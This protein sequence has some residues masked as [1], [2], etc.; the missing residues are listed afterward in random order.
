MATRK[1]TGGNGKAPARTTTSDK[2]APNTAAQTPSGTV[3][4]LKPAKAASRTAAAARARLAAV[5]S[6]EHTPDDHSPTPPKSPRAKYGRNAL[7]A[8]VAADTGLKRTEVRQVLDAA[9]GRM[10]AA[11]GA[12]R[13]LDL[14]PF[15]KL[16]A[17]K[18]KQGRNGET[19]VCRL[20]LSDAAEKPGAEPLAD[21]EEGR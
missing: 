16:R 18:R 7:L 4:A 11:I 14:A 1:T 13:D 15:G 17:V 9:L 10:N 3:T 19:I 8:E 5:A 12:G 20:R 21:T 2:T 6:H